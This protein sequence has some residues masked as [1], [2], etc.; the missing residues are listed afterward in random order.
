LFVK[1]DDKKYTPAPSIIDPDKINHMGMKPLRAAK[2][3]NILM[4][5]TMVNPEQTAFISGANTSFGLK[6]R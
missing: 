5:I 1:Y 6:S 3:I 2:F 4:E